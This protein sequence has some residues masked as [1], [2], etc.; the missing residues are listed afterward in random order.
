MNKLCLFRPLRRRAVARVVFVLLLCFSSS[1]AARVERLIDTWRPTHYLVNVTLN[2]QL[3]EI[4][5]ASARVDVRILK[6][7]RVIDFDFGELTVDRVTLSSKPLE[8][9][10]KD[11]KLLVTLSEVAQS[12]AS[13]TLTIDYHG[14]PKDGLILTKD[15]DGNA[16]AVGDN[17]PNRVH[18]WIPALDHPSAKATITFNITAPANQEVVA[19]GK[20]DHVETTATGQRTWTYSEG[21]PIPPYC[22]II[23]VGQF[24]KVEPTE[25]AVTPLSYYVPLSERDLA[26]KG[27]SPGAPVLDFFTRTVAPY[28][29]EKLALIVGATRFGGMENSSAIVFTSNMFSRAPSAL[30]MSQRFGI[31]GN[32]VSLIAHEIAH[33][34]FGDSVTESTWSDLWLSEGFATYFAGLFVQRYEGEDAFQLY[35]KNAAL[36][37]LAYEKKSSAPIFDRDTESL[38]DLLNANNYQKGSWVLH[39]LRSNLGD[40][41]FFRGIKSYYESHKNSTA[42]TEDL[43]AA[44]EKASGKNLRAFFT[45]WVYESGH[46]QYELAWYWLGKKELRLVLTQRQA[47][48]AFTDPVP[49]TISTAKGKRDI[50]LKPIGK[51]LIERVP[52]REKPTAVEVDPRNVLLDET[53]V[54]SN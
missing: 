10:H 33:Q 12:G 18:H 50:V 49:V 9:T 31:P 44:L 36:A 23:A 19:N 29:Y 13:L 20:L 51:L 3:S 15:K 5:S 41:A 38:M 6:P 53:T 4:T 30:G 35:M 43:R 39:M 28:P 2:D 8:F 17:W 52:L 34:W 47:G 48:N 11:G 40:D 24:A 45:R 54:K 16:A 37:V 46:P 26:L 42:S 25:R 27:F 1:L 21:V 14:K 32:N 7:T 22:M